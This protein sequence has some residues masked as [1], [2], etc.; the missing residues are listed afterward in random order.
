MTDKETQHNVH[1]ILQLVKQFAIE[2]LSEKVALEV[3]LKICLDENLLIREGISLKEKES[4]KETLTKA[5]NTFL[6]ILDNLDLTTSSNVTE[7]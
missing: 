3:F 5:Y 4:I 1:Q 2:S 7:H 6:M